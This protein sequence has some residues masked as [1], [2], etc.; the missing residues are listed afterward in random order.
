MNYK[1]I[2]SYTF[3]ISECIYGNKVSDTVANFIVQSDYKGGFRYA[4]T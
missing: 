2:R 4:I 3:L 1:Y